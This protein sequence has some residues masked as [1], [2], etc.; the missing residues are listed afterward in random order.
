MRSRALANSVEH[1]LT[2]VS[3][4]SSILAC[5]ST[6][7][8]SSQYLPKQNWTYSSSSATLKDAMI[9]SLR[10][11]NV[12]N[13]FTNQR[14]EFGELSSQFQI[15]QWDIKKPVNVSKMSGQRISFA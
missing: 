6:S 7:S 10:R 15:A 4:S 1:H 11:H 3:E 8:S 12:R 5:A 9:I 14:L 2:P 13:P